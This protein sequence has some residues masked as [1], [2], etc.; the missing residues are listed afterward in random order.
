MNQAFTTSL[1][2][3]A[4]TS[5][6]Y[7]SH[8]DYSSSLWDFPSVD[9]CFRNEALPASVCPLDTAGAFAATLVPVPD[10]IPSLSPN[11][12]LPASSSFTSLS[13]VNGTTKAPELYNKSNF[14]VDAAFL[15][16]EQVVRTRPRGRPRKDLSKKQTTLPPSDSLMKYRAKNR[17]AS[18]R[19]REKEKAQAA[20]LD[21]VFQKQLQRNLALKQREA[22]LREEL[23]S[24]QM[25]AL[26]HGS[27]ECEEVKCYNR[28][29]AQEIAIAWHLK[30][31]QES[32]HGIGLGA[33]DIFL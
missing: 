11:S 25:Q 23:F 32:N 20:A 31:D 30:S 10:S 8:P 1:Y 12:T 3:E 6:T 29:R 5:M 26:H 7:V 28:Q 22:D 24:L 13:Q 27:C 17:R 18:A 9:D 4:Q 15:E 16:P 2:H 14:N 33:Q 19:C 21:E